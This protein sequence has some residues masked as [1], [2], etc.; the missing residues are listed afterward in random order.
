[1]DS[2]SGR[3]G[4]WLASTRPSAAYICDPV[5]PSDLPQ[6][7]NAH[8][9][10]YRR[11]NHLTFVLLDRSHLEISTRERMT[12][13]QKASCRDLLALTLP[14]RSSYVDLRVQSRPSVT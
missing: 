5:A 4:R 6:R 3:D 11:E 13:P 12:R 9:G 14:L 2:E 1:M 8:L 7:S 10:F